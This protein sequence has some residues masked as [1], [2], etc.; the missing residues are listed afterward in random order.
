M[1]TMKGVYDSRRISCKL[2][3]RT[4]NAFSASI[5]LYN[6]E[7]WTLTR[8][9]ENKIDA[10]HRR[11][12]RRALNIYWPRKISNEELYRKTHAEPWSVTIRR[13]LNW[14]GHL[15]RLEESTPARKALFEVLTPAKKN[16]G[17]P[18]QTWINII[19]EDLAR[20]NITLNVQTTPMQTTIEVLMQLTT[21][22]VQW[23]KTVKDIMAVIR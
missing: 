23:R 11:M 22:R 18:P 21:D 4:F 5:F 10:F 13:R 3:L 9:L 12:L 2:K 1:K 20:I 15:M 19:E 8:T 17:R 16:I 14:L 7:L 6:A